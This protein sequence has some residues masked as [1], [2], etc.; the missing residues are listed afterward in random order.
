MVWGLVKRK[1]REVREGSPPIHLGN[2]AEDANAGFALAVDDVLNVFLYQR[3][4]GLTHPVEHVVQHVFVFAAV[5]KHVIEGGESLL[6]LAEFDEC[7]GSH[8]ANFVFAVF[9]GGSEGVSGEDGVP[10]QQVEADDA[11]PAKTFV[12][13]ILGTDK[14]SKAGLVTS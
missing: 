10:F 14:G 13:F 7:P 6:G 12:R 8:D 1:V 2:P 9:E 11:P 4:C 5:H 3:E